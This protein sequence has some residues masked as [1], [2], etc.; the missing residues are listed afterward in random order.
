MQ[1]GAIAQSLLEVIL[2]VGLLDNFNISNFAVGTSGKEIY[3]KTLTIDLEEK[4]VIPDEYKNHIYK[5]SGFMES[6]QLSD[7][8]IR[9]ML[10][11]F[12]VKR[13]RWDVIIDG[14]NRK[15]SRDWSLI[16]QGTRMSVEYAAFL[17][18]ISRF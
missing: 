11:I 15:V 1:D 2:P 8:P 3:S 12:H 9:D 5:S 16:E 4:N 10:V 7:Y 14:K 6:R 17:K 18:E 13:R